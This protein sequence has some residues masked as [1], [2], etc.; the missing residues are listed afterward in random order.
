MIPQRKAERKNSQGSAQ[1]VYL[2]VFKS[3]TLQK[4]L[5]VEATMRHTLRFAI[6]AWRAVRQ[7][8]MAEI[9]QCF[10]KE[11]AE[12]LKSTSQEYVQLRASVTTKVS[13]FVAAMERHTKI[14]VFS[15]LP[16]AKLEGKTRSWRWRRKVRERIT[17]YYLLENPLVL[18][19][20][21]KLSILREDFSFTAIPE[22]K[23]NLYI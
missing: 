13:L 15:S 16:N 22:T 18:L 8:K 21:I 6:F 19:L 14:L 3:T 20:M 4:V 5:C 11:N 12:N 7:S 9:W 1:L 17:N 2:T 23:A 10:T